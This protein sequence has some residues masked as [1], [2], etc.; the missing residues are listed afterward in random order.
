V[1]PVEQE[2]LPNDDLDLMAIRADTLFAYDA[3]R[4]MVRNN[5]P[6]GDP[7]PLVFL[8]CTGSGYVLRIGQAV[9][10]AMVESLTALVGTAP[11][12]N[13]LH[14]PLAIETAVCEELER[15]APVTDTGGGPAYRFPE[16]VAQ[17]S[18]VVQVTAENIDLVRDT[19]PWQYR[20]LAAS[21]PCFAVV[22]NGAAVS[23][24]FSSR[25]GANACEAGVE[26]LPDF[27]SRGYA[28]AVTAAWGVFVRDSGRIPLYSTSWDNLA[29]Q[30]VARRLGLIMFGADATWA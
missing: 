19:F 13:D 7:A 1:S 23:I 9:P 4:R 16:H 28:S 22:R 30:G 12:A 24:C 3:R 5:E 27:R 2:P 6:D 11:A 25:I 17:R 14:I 20:E 26:T 15:H 21:W 10:D 18:D 29:S 8:G